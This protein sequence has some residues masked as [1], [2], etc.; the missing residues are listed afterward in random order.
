MLSLDLLSLV[1]MM[2]PRY[3]QH[4]LLMRSCGK[5]GRRCRNPPILASKISID[6]M[7][8][9]LTKIAVLVAESGCDSVF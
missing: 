9:S 7:V 3:T 8:R 5:T 2:V 4:T 1:D 6:A